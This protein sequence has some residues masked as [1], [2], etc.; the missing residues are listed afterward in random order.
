MYLTNVHERAKNNRGSGQALILL[1]F[2]MKRRELRNLN[3]KSQS[4]F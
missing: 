4:E 1:Y 2:A 3:H